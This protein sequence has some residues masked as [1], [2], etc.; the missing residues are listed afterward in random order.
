MP[1]N[2][3]SNKKIAKNTL[4]LYVRMIIV[5]LIS[6]VTTRVVMKALGVEDFGTYNIVCGFVALFAVF[7]TSFSTTINRFYNFELGKNDY[8]G[9]A[10]VYR[11]SLLIQLLLAFVLLV[12]L[13][14]IGVYYLNCKMVLPDGR[15]VVANW[16]F[17][18]SVLSM[19]FTVFQ[20]PY[21][22]AVMAFERMD[23]YAL[24]SVLDS[25]LKVI[26]AYSLLYLDYDRLLLYSVSMCFISAL[27]FILYFGYCK[28]KI[29]YIWKRT[30]F[31]KTKFKAILTFSGWSVLDPLS[32]ITRDQGI[33]IVMNSFF[34][35]AI[36][37][38]QGI[39]YQISAAVDSFGSGITTSFRP[40]VTQSY[41][42]GNYFRTNF[43]MFSMSKILFWL[44]VVLVLPICFEID[45][46]LKLW[47]GDN[48]PVFTSTFAVLVLITKAINSFN[49]PIT[50]V[51]AAT[52][53][54]K[55]IR[56]CTFSTITMII[57][58][59]ILLY[60]LGYP[61]W[62]AYVV[63]ILLTFINQTFAVL[64]LRKTFSCF[65]IMDYL[66]SIIFPCALFVVLASVVPWCVTA[67][68]KP[69]VYRL[70][71]TIFCSFIFSVLSAYGLLLTK[72]EKLF[73]RKVLIERF[74]S[75]KK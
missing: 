35:T 24:V 44:Q 6:L 54:I 49:A 72:D 4:F 25:V 26:F 63:M 71:I 45:C 56:I 57:P 40:Q 51:M 9:V 3:S 58:F 60:T 59:S 70:V 69:S 75:Y 42:E 67:L 10:T 18:F 8:I 55:N 61:A 43:L 13:E 7:N 28:Y 65:S 74:R 37:A 5:L 41:S 31:D 48:I 16:I 14:V 62:S 39:A 27:N 33:N 21:T 1:D 46:I 17:Q 38:A 64:I 47:L 30:I 50:Q 20:A 68:I 2:S 29:P 73:L 11:A 32:Y 66:H 36:N 34:G 53:H 15:L 52:G 23:Y 12:L 19:L 22:A